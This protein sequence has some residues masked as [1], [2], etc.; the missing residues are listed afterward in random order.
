MLCSDAGASLIFFCYTQCHTETFFDTRKYM[1]LHKKSILKKTALVSI[2]LLFSKL[3]GIP[4]EILQVRYLGVGPL[5][6]AFNSA[7]KIPS[8]LRRIFAE[9]AM[10]AAFIPTIVKVMRNDSERQASRL[11]T[12]MYIVFGTFIMGLCL[13]VSIFPE[14]FVQLAAPGFIDKPVELAAATHLL[15]ILIYSVFFIFSSALLAGALQAKMH[16]AIPSWGP[17]LH[18]VFYIGGLTTCLMYG[19][20]VSSFAGFL[21]LGGFVHMVLCLWVYFKLNFAIIW[22]DKTTYPYFKEVLY[23]FLPCLVSVGIIEI[24]LLIDTRFA[25]TLPSGSVTLVNTASKFMTIALGAF[26]A[27][28]SSI[29]LSHFSRISTYAPKRLSFYL[30]E[31][32][33]FIFWVTVPV[34]I[35]MGFFSYD[36]F[37]T[38]FYRLAKNNFTLDRVAEGSALLIAFLPGLFFFSLNKMMLSIYYSLHEM[39]YTTAITIIGTVSNIVLNRLLMPS[40]GAVGI[41]SAT[42]IAAVIQSILFLIM[43]RKKFG[44]VL[45]YKRFGRFLLAYG[46]QLSVASV[47]FYVLYKLC[48]VAI[49]R[50]MPGYADFFLHHIGL[51]FWVGPLCLLIAGLVYYLRNK[52]GTR[53]YFLD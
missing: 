8:L 47:L 14:P 10:S 50:L 34:A 43:L 19:L 27:A 29:L 51:W 23:K 40:Y 7:L 25:S 12:L 5:S 44:F 20:S 36:I 48:V 16:F 11:M 53:L 39:N 22:P 52:Y 24:N 1:A 6:D 38:L 37:Y 35:L 13:L 41:A 17:A 3:L 32:T 2:S 9:G 18:N 21:L 28:F 15:Q 49:Q 31:S 26:A 46:M 4:R 30:L 33:K 45:Y 42:S